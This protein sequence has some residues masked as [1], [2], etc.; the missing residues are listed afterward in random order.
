MGYMW[1]EEG[2]RHSRRGL[3]KGV[4]HVLNHIAA[5]GPYDGIYGFS[6]GALIATLATQAL[7]EAISKGASESEFQDLEKVDPWRFVL[8]A[9][10]SCLLGEE[11]GAEDH[12][13]KL[14][15]PAL[16]IFGAKDKILTRS[17]KLR[18]MYRSPD[19]YEM[20]YA[21]HGVPMDAA[22]DFELKA[23]IKLF[24]SKLRVQ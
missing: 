20:S 5:N 21:G 10:G 6:N 1:A 17:L 22:S 3:H 15:T 18:E 2:G 8:A 16:H 23:A 24:F 7:E 19:S 13:P 14:T 11:E 4:Q 12:R 9:C